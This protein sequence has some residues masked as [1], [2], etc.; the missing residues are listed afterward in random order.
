MPLTNLYGINTLVD[1]LETYMLCKSFKL[2]LVN[3][4]VMKQAD[5]EYDLF[6]LVHSIYIYIYIIYIFPQR[7]Y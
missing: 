1:W 6:L 2:V 3:Y 7:I 4:V 5:K